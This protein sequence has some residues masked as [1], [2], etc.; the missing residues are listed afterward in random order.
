MLADFFKKTE[1][2]VVIFPC[3]WI[4]ITKLRKKTEKKNRFFV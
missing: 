2:L 1:R 3:M 4:V